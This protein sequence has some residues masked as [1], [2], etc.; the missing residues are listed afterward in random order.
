MQR[1]LHAS[2][3]GAAE[4]SKMEEYVDVVSVF[5]LLA[6]PSEA[7]AKRPLF[8]AHTQRGFKMKEAREER[9]APKSRC[10]VS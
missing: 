9:R 8:D 5:V 10:P 2:L 6:R 4:K 3:R 7:N 1:E